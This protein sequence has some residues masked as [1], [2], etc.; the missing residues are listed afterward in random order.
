MPTTLIYVETASGLL[1]SLA[2]L[3]LSNWAHWR[4][5]KPSNLVVAYLL[6]K[7]ACCVLSATV[8]HV[9]HD[10]SSETIQGCLI[11]VLVLLELC[12]KRALLLGPYQNEPP[13]ATTSFL[14]RVFFTWI[15]PILFSGYKTILR[16][17]DLPSLDQNID[18]KNLRQSILQAWDQ[19]GACLFQLACQF[20]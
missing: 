7:L 10:R 20:P 11:A 19:R 12:S 4:S 17:D 3:W 2:L 15:N 13:E 14:G 8:P 9:P 16:G 18:S 6:A 5:I 1:G